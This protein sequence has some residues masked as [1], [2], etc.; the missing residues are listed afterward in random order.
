MIKLQRIAIA[1]NKLS[2]IY[3]YIY[4]YNKQIVINKGEI[5]KSAEKANI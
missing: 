5:Q 1:N 4:I 3:I 2:Y